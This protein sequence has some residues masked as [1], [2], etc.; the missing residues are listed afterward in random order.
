MTSNMFTEYDVAGICERTGLRP[1]ETG[2]RD[3]MRENQFSA[4]NQGPAFGKT[5]MRLFSQIETNERVSKQMPQDS[6]KMHPLSA[7]LKGRYFEHIVSN[8]REGCP[9]HLSRRLRSTKFS[10]KHKV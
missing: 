9:R 7:V 8:E 10:V 1:N 5:L 4:A 6:T 2:W 3:L